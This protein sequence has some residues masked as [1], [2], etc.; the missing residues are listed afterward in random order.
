[1]TSHIKHYIDLADITSVRFECK[2]CTAALSFPLS[3]DFQSIPKA[4]PAC[5]AEWVNLSSSPKPGELVKNFSE[6]HAQLLRM[7]AKEHPSLVGFEFRLELNPDA[8]LVP[9]SAN[10]V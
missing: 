6:A 1:M 8:S 10:R 7:L 5:S 9:V 2:R 4:C 3:A